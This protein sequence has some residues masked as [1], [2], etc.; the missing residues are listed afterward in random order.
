MNHLLEVAC[1]PHITIQVL[2]FGAGSTVGLLGGF[3]IA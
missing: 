3:V 2:P 1:L